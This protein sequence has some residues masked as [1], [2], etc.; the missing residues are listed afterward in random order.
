MR[1]LEKYK[2]NMSNPVERLEKKNLILT[3]LAVT[4]AAAGIT[5][6][7]ALKYGFICADILLIADTTAE[8]ILNI[9][10]RKRKAFK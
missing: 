10:S 8:L 9:K 3:M 5:Q 2:K 4:G 1:L 6:N 7:K